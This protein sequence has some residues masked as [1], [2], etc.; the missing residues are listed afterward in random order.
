[1]EQKPIPHVLIFPLPAQGHVNSM[2]K[3]AELLCLSE[4]LHVTYLNTQH[5]H[6]RLLRYT[7]AQTRFACFPN[8]KFETISDGLPDEHSRTIE[9]LKDM[10]DN[11][12]TVVKPSFRELLNRKSDTRPPVTCVIGDGLFTFV[13]DVAKEFQI[14]TV[15]FRTASACY[16]WSLFCYQNLVEAGE[17][18]FQD[19]DM[20]KMVACVPGMEAF[21]RRKD[22]PSFFRAKE[23]DDPVLQVAVTAT[24]NS[25]RASA[26]ILNTFEELE[27]PILSIMKDHFPKIYAIGPLHALLKSKRKNAVSTTS[28]NSLWEVDRSCLEWLDSQPVKSVV[29]VSFGSIV[30]MKIDEMFEFW[31]GLVDSGKRFLWVHRPNSVLHRDEKNP[32]PAKLLEGTKER[33]YIVGWSPQ[34]E[35]L[36]HPAVGGFVTHSGWN[37]TLETMIAGVPMVCWPQLGDQQINSR[38]VSEVWNVGLDMKDTCERSMIE[39]LVID[40]MD[41]KKDELSKSMDKI[42]Q[43]ARKSISEGGSSYRNLDALIEVIKSMSLEV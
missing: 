39:K 9:N 30:S 6:H 13:V 21:L 14:P 15:S 33:G 42:S 18:P 20:D 2:L 8:F 4:N 5:Y 24:M 16:L 19:E 10:F 37:S 41:R 40:L 12:E 1:M 38:F 29:Y 25:T 35:V 11:L 3:L 27:G 26:S 23:L 32:I 36:V 43:L 7:D 22:L 28:S 17:L 31:H 34:E